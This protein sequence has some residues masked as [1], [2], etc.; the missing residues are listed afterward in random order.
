MIGIDEGHANLFDRSKFN[1]R[2]RIQWDWA[3]NEVMNESL[4]PQNFQDFCKQNHL[5]YSPAA[6]KDVCRSLLL[7]PKSL[8][9]DSCDGE[10]SQ[11]ARVAYFDSSQLVRLHPHQS[12]TYL[13]RGRRT[14]DERCPEGLEALEMV[15]MHMGEEARQR[16]RTIIALPKVV[17]LMMVMLFSADVSFGPGLCH[18]Y[19]ECLG[20][21][22][23]DCQPGYV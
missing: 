16:W 17:D 15:G 4:D 2:R 5:I 14:V 9:Q 8:A 13:A 23:I 6:R 12:K 21:L 3:L 19:S 20:T 18:T 22:E 11:A 1:L 7:L 10:I